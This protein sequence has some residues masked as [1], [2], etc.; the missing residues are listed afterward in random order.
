MSSSIRKSRARD[1]IA[2]SIPADQG[3]EFVSSGRLAATDVASSF[4]TFVA[5]PE[6]VRTKKFSSS[7]KNKSMPGATKLGSCLT[8]MTHRG[9]ARLTFVCLPLC[10]DPN[11][12]TTII[13]AF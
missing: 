2:S 1:K 3:T 4:T 7:T 13:A 6:P 8:D 9:R 5:L 12:Y 10:C 11:A